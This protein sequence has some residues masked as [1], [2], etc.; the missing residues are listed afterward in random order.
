[1]LSSVLDLGSELINYLV[2]AFRAISSGRLP[3]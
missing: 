3:F 1:M 2:W